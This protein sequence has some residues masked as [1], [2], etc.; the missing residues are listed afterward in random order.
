MT[1]SPTSPCPRAGHVPWKDR[2]APG[3]RGFT[4]VEVVTA[5]AVLAL[6][7]TLLGQLVG[8]MSRT[9]IDG[10]RRVNNFTKSR[11]M[12]DLFVFDIQS[13]VFRSDLAAFP[14]SSPTF[15]TMRSGVAQASSPRGLCLV[16]YSYDAG[17]TSRAAM[18][19]IRRG[20][21][22]VLWDS[23]ATRISFGNSTT[24]PQIPGIT[25]RDAAQGVVAFKLLFIR[26]DGTFSDTYAP[27]SDA[28][29]SRAVG[30][31]LAVVDDTALGQLVPGQIAALRARLDGAA[32]GKRSVLADWE[33][34]L[35]G[36]RFEWNAFPK[37]LA[38][39]L[40]IF[41]RYAPLPA[42]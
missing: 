33:A 2:I 11:A 19:T 42:L 20:D 8:T 21:M 41:E 26:A 7:L 22:A 10:Q 1:S 38:Q 9:W 5:V 6:L 39:G 40:Q 29:P 36:S 37:S 18:T 28:N 25:P 13:G 12:L 15:Y 16:Q 35:N 31:T 27:P 3:R 30:M 32:T 24:L 23:P 17:A 34:S 4:L 14:A